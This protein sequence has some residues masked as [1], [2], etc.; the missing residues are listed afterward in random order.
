MH[1][2]ADDLI[3]EINRRCHPSDRISIDYGCFDK[4]TR[5]ANGRE[6]IL[7]AVQGSADTIES[8]LK[9]AEAEVEDLGIKLEN[10]KEEIESLRRQ[11]NAEKDKLRSIEEVCTE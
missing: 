3:E 5:S 4:I 10:A 8:E 7:K 1:I 2:R 6:F 9:D 11:L